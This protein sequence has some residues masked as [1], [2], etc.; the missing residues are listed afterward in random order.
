MSLIVKRATKGSG[1]TS[2]EIDANVNNL[3]NDKVEINN[4][5]F[6]S[7]PSLVNNLI[8]LTGTVLPA[9]NPSLNLDFAN[10]KQLDP[11]ITFSR[12]TV[13]T[14]CDGK[15]TK[16][17]EQNLLT[18][19]QDFSNAV[20]N[21][22]A[23]SIGSLV[24][25]PDG[26]LTATPITADGTTGT[27]GLS[28]SLSSGYIR[29]A[30]WYVKAGT[31][32]YVQIYFGGDGNP[33][34]NFDLSTGVL[35][36]SGTNI[37]PTITS[38]GSG[39]YRISAYTNS[40]TATNIAL[41]IISSATSERA[42]SNSLTTSVQVWGAQLEQRAFASTYLPTT[43]TAITNYVSAIIAAPAGVPRFDYD[44][45][46]KK[47][48]GLLIEELRTN[49]LLNSTI[50]G[51]N[52][53]TQSITTTAVARTLSFYGT[54]SVT[55]SGRVNILTKT[56]DFSDAVWT[57]NFGG[58]GI[59]PVVTLNAGVAPDGTSTAAQVIFNTGVGT[60]SGDIS[61]LEQYS[62]NKTTIGTTYS[63]GVWIKGTSGQKIQIRQQAASGYNL[64]T[65]TGNW[66]YFTQVEV[67]G[68]TAAIMDIGLRQGVNGTIN[69]NITVLLWHPDIRPTNTT[70]FLPAYQRVNTTTDF[71]PATA[72]ITGLGA[73]PTRTTY[74]YTPTAGTLTLTVSGT[75]QYA[76]DEVGAF[77]TSYI[78]TAG[79]ALSR[80]A[81]SASMT[82]VNFSSWYNQSE[83]SLYTESDDNGSNTNGAAT[84]FNIGANGNNA[85]AFYGTGVNSARLLVR[86]N[87][88]FI[89]NTSSSVTT[90]PIK[91]AASFK[92]GAVSCTANGSLFVTNVNVNIP[93][94]L[95]TLYIGYY[96]GTVSYFTGHIR[97][98][99]YYP[100]ALTSV[101]LQGLTS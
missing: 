85:I 71:T 7:A 58:T 10:G 18:Y 8:P 55:L 57:K 79:T 61:L 42:E 84:L 41:A 89:I 31:N 36:S 91:Q 2:S 93:H 53:A 90:Q 48:L 51:A 16:L 20:W 23:V 66:D 32:N 72:T 27:K 9:I 75:V 19:S 83:G 4:P 47:P 25:S 50:D 28:Y 11:R 81:D 29:T 87:A 101:E 34:I 95:D 86:L 96:P 54:G 40:L 30:S 73:Y 17:A 65:L 5:N 98:L 62:A 100:K 94:N 15:T 24:T 97:K 78:P 80:A 56:E 6:K 22:V 39:W 70:N 1:L 45:V 64:V 37:T 26:T 35:G 68:I 52:L 77:A 13:A 12:N 43:N 33:W 14:Y 74:T 44:P 76:N 21:K 49:S 99:T 60:T 3:N 59:T 67:S 82:G 88:A 63:S 69:S 92:D 38:L 46:T